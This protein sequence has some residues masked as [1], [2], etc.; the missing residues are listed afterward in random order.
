MND[1]LAFALA[2]CLALCL[3]VF[4]V[5][6]ILKDPKQTADQ[7]VQESK[8]FCARAAVDGERRCF[9]DEKTCLKPMW[10]GDQGCFVRQNTHC[11]HIS[12][13]MRGEYFSKNKTDTICYPSIDECRTQQ[14]YIA[15]KQWDLRD[16]INT[17]K[18]LENWQ[19]NVTQEPVP[20]LTECI[21][22]KSDEMSD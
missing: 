15:Q 6:V 12:S 1:G 19:C 2:C 22:M 9:K 10:S 7:T 3:A 17:C 18:R 11:Y 14:G 16:R 5:F 21:E 20:V 4:D 13:S 8:V